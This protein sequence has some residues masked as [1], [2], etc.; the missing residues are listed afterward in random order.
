MNPCYR[1]FLW[2][3]W[4]DH[5]WHEEELSRRHI[6]DHR[7]NGLSTMEVAK[8]VCCKCKMVLKNEPVTYADMS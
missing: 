3:K 1:K 8:F 6:T 4:E 7:H 5:C 2:W